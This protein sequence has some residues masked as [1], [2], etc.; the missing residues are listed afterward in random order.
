MK[1]QGCSVFGPV[2]TPQALCG[3]LLFLLLLT[4]HLYAQPPQGLLFEERFNGGAFPPVGWTVV[5]RDDGPLTP[6]F[7]GTATSAIPP[8]EG[9]GFAA[10]NFQRSNGPYLDDYLITPPI[11]GIGETGF[12]DSLIFMTSSVLYAPPTANVPDSLMILLSAAGTDTSDFTLELDYFQVAKGSWERRAYLLTGTVPM[13]STVQIAFRYLHYAGGE[14]GM[15]SDFVGIDHVR[16]ERSVSTGAR[17]ITS[18]PSGFALQNNYP[19][20]FNSQTTIQFSIVNSQYTILKVYDVLGREVATLVDKPLSAGN[21]SIAWDARGS[22]SGVYF[23]RLSAGRF[24]AIGQ[25]VHL[26]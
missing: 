23:Y 1:R 7:P 14:S 15:S 3:V 6:W 5:N 10:D 19:N 2:H 18:L 17:E 4:A 11:S 26:K 25:M 13:S 9:T 8:F 22:A 24:S 16:V 20:P 12:M 21:H